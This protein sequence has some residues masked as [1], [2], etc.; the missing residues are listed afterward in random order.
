MASIASAVRTKIT[1][2]NI[3]NVTTKV[4]R[5]MAPDSVALPF[6]TFMSDLARTPE[7]EGDGI[8]K[9]RKQMMQIDLWQQLT[10]EDV[11]IVEAL[12]AAVDGAD[13]TGVDK[14]VFKCKVADIQRLVDLDDNICHHALTVEVVHT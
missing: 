4:Y 6:V 3:T 1:A 9:A 8:V 12:L 10:S 7:L 11:A 14:T 2:A 5:D 13:L